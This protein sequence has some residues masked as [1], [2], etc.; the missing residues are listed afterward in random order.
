MNEK[1]NE[2]EKKTKEN[3]PQMIMNNYFFLLISS[4]MVFPF[5]WNNANRFQLIWYLLVVVRK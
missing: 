5:S 1:E 3:Q 4:N 2:N